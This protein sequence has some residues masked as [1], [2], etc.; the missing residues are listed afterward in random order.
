VTVRTL[1]KYGSP[2]A[3]D[4]NDAITSLDASAVARTAVGAETLSTHRRAAGDVTGN[5]T[6]S[7]LDASNIARFAVG[8]VDHFPVAVAAQSDWKFEKCD[9]SYPTNCGDPAYSF[10]PFTAAQTGKSFYA[11]LY[12]EV[13]GNWEPV[14]GGLLAAPKGTS[15]EEQAAI[16]HDRD[17]AARFER[18]GRRIPLERRAGAGPAELSLEGW[19]ALRAGERI[20]LTVDLRNADGILGLDLLLTYDPSR[21]SIVGGEA[22]GIGSGWSVAQAD[23]RGTYRIAAYGLTPLS[24]SGSVFKLTVEA[25]GQTGRRDAPSIGGAANEGAIPLRVR[26]RG[27]TPSPAGR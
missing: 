24:G 22:T 9:P 26:E 13:T 12:G 5:G 4:H 17:Q 18:E 16:A 20:D 3:S 11:L 14:G 25:S 27:Q 23:Q 7:A 21:I 8:L 2:R 6:L 10:D 15:P 1:S 19:K